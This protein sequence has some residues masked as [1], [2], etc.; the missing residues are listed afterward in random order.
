[1]TVLD[2]PTAFWH[3]LCAD[4]TRSDPR[5]PEALRLVIL[6]GERALPEALRRWDQAFEG[7]GT[8]PVL[9]NSYGPTE[10]TVVCTTHSIDP[11]SDAADIPIGRPLPGVRAA[12]LDSA[13]EPVPPGVPGELYLGGPS[14]AR[15]YVGLPDLTA[16]RFVTLEGPDGPWRAY[17]TGDRVCWRAD[18]V[19]MFRGRVDR[20]LKIRGHRVEPDE[21]E[22]LIM[23][24]GARAAAVDLRDG[25]AG[26]R[27]VAWV[28]PGLCGEETEVLRRALSA[29]LPEALIPSAWVFVPQLP[30]NSH[31]KVDLKALPAPEND[32]ARPHTPPEDAIERQLATI[33]SALLGNESI[34]REDDFFA[35]G[36]HSLLAFSLVAR[37]EREFGRSLPLVS[38]FRRPTLAAQAA[39]LRERE[40]AR[41]MRVPLGEGTQDPPLVLIHPGGSTLLAYQALVR[42]MGSDGPRVLGIEARGFEAGERPHDDIEQMAACYLDALRAAWPTGPVR[43]AGWCFGG[44]IVYEMSRLLRLEGREVTLVTMI[45]TYLASATLQRRGGMPDLTDIITATLPALFAVTIEREVLLGLS[46]D[47]QMELAW[48]RAGDAGTL[49]PEFDLARMRRLLDVAFHHEHASARYLPAHN[50]GPVTLIRARDDAESWLSDTLGWEALATSVEVHWLPGRHLSLFHPPYVAELA[51]TLC[52]LT[53]TT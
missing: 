32:R 27:L 51:R 22:T 50:P 43:L 47:A 21:V 23:R 3:F 33:W 36:G 14:L 29:S 2:L 44:L 7:R 25:G 6:G 40:H 20:Q 13:G 46:P 8:R 5:L 45:D 17:R 16:E 28:V 9:M 18:G 41:E 39:L 37:I 53:G 52:E 15:G 12:V 48:R 38:V 10:T 34:G 31:G 49:P 26:P 1:V 24:A 35:L 4:L 19:L 30:L 11:A 42:E